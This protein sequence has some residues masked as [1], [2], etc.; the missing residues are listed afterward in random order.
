MPGF[1]IGDGGWDLLRRFLE[2]GRNGATTSV[3]LEGCDLVF[4]VGVSDFFCA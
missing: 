4:G 1:E 2:D 3:G